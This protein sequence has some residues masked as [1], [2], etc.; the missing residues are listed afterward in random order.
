MQQ[1]IIPYPINERKLR[2]GHIEHIDFGNKTFRIT[3]PHDVK[4]GSK[5][6]LKGIAGNVDESFRGQDLILLLKKDISTFS[7]INRDIIMDLPVELDQM[8]RSSIKRIN[9]GDRK[10]DIKIPPITKY[11]HILRMPG[12]ADI[13]NGGYPGD[14]LLKVAK[15]PNLN[16]GILHMIYGCFMGFDNSPAERKFKIGIKLPWIF[17]LSDEFIFRSNNS[18]LHGE[19]F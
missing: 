7:S 5:L 1:V 4:I 18:R 13:L 9:L 11:G 17:E 3:L 8:R 2:G 19:Y 6:R 16:K 12:K 10:F 14:V 15:N